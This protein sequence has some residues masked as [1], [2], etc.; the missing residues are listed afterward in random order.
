MPRVSLGTAA[1]L[2]SRREKS[3]SVAGVHDVRFPSRTR[4]PGRGS[5]EAHLSTDV[6]EALEL[7]LGVVAV[8][9]GWNHR[10]GG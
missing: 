6:G 7:V 2:G 1:T 4:P 3:H 5:C 9:G 8:L 10:S